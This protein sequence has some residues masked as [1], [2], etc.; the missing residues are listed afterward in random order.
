MVQDEDE[1]LQEWTMGAP[2]AET[3]IVNRCRSEETYEQRLANGTLP[4]WAGSSGKS[5]PH[6]REL[7]HPPTRPD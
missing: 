2:L 5:H 1:E 3:T 7:T 6:N 4:W